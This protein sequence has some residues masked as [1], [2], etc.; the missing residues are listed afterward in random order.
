MTMR[1]L[2]GDEADHLDT[3]GDHVTTSVGIS[4]KDW[5]RLFERIDSDHFDPGLPL[6]LL[7]FLRGQGYSC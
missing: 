5:A 7:A 3:T 1:H 6:L 4:T 2:S